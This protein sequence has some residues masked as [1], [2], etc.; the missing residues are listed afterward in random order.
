MENFITALESTFKKC[1]E[2]KKKKKEA[3]NIGSISCIFVQTIG[4]D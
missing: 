2:D 1:K 3:E 4:W